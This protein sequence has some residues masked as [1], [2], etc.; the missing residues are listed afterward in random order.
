[1]RRI[2]S[3]SGLL[4][5]LIILLTIIAVT[6]V[7]IYKHEVSLQRANE[8]ALQSNLWR[9]RQA[10]AF[11]RQDKQEGPPNLEALVAARYLREIPKD[12]ICGECPWRPVPV[13]PREPK[14][15]QG[16][17]DVKSTAPGQD[18]KGKAYNEY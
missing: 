11:Y 13:D 3:H 15:G 4:L 12:P 2:P 14:I 5:V 8:V 6:T 17:G 16:I 9:M 7:S 1:M 18:A 10:I